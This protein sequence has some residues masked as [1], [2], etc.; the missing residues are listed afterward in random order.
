[1]ARTAIPIQDVPF[2][3][4]IDNLTWTAADAVNNHEFDNNGHVLLL[5]RNTDAAGKTVTVVSVADEYGRTGDKA[6]TVPATTGY[7]TA[8]PFKPSLWNQSGTGKTNVNVSAAT[9]L[10]LAAIRIVPS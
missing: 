3:G 9:G 4:S 5:A 6:I 2:Q 8:G 7:A 10:S 1:M